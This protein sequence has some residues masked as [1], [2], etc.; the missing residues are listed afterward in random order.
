MNAACSTH[1]GLSRQ[2]HVLA[3]LCPSK[4]APVPTEL[5]M[6]GLT[7][8]LIAVEDRNLLPLSGNESPFQG[9]AGSDTE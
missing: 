2:C 8:G 6:V 3:V 5:V 1:A 9:R 4:E 7:A